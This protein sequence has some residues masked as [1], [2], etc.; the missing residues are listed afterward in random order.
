MRQGSAACLRAIRPCSI[1]RR[2]RTFA[3]LPSFAPQLL[4][5]L[6]GTHHVYLRLSIISRLG[7]ALITFLLC[8]RDACSISVPSCWK[9]DS[10]GRALSRGGFCWDV[11]MVGAG[12]DKEE[13]SQVFGATPSSWAGRCLWK[14]FDAYERASG[15]PPSGLSRVTSHVWLCL[16][17]LKCVDPTLGSKGEM[18]CEVSP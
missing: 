16:H 8:I 6:A 10:P 3:H 1:P 5:I 4:I 2:S 13:A 17:G 12:E 9:G 15:P 7:G 11:T 18:V 14:C